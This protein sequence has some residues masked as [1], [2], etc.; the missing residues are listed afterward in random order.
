MSTHEAPNLCPE[1]REPLFDGC[2]CVDVDLTADSE[3]RR[4]RRGEGKSTRMDW[5]RLEME[6]SD[7][8]VLQQKETDDGGMQQEEQQQHSTWLQEEQQQQSTWRQG[9]ATQKRQDQEEKDTLIKTVKLRMRQE[10][11]QEKV[12][13]EEE[14]RRESEGRREWE[15]AK[16]GD[17]RDGEREQARREIS[18]RKGVEKV[19]SDGP[20]EGEKDRKG[21]Q[22]GGK[23]QGRSGRP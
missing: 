23:G 3:R 20:R 15:Q 17:P 12:S 2:E 16:K 1:C 6:G 19:K 11:M 18:E 14:A 8:R 5:D 13:A 9:N 10:E 21:T 4:I 22:T 7:K